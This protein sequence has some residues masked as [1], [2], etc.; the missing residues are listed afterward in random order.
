MGKKRKIRKKRTKHEI[1]LYFKCID[2]CLGSWYIVFKTTGRYDQAYRGYSGKL[3]CDNTYYT[4]IPT[5]YL[6]Y[7]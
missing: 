6:F 5:I 3:H 7:Y 4:N 2:F 1:I